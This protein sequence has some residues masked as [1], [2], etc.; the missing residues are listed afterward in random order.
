[1]C[2]KVKQA[3]FGRLDYHLLDA[4]SWTMDVRILCHVYVVSLGDVFADNY[5]SYHR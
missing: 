1:M 5:R 4:V 3:L 2:T